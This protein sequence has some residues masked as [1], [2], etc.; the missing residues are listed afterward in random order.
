[1]IQRFE[2]FVTGITVCY[3]YIQRIKS[4]EMVE[5]GLRG[6]HVMCLFYLNRHPEGLTAAQLCSLCAEDKAAISRTLAELVEKGL[7]APPDPEGRKKYR[8]L[9]QLT[10]EGR[11]IADQVDQLCAQWITAGSAGLSNEQRE[12]F[13]AALELI[14]ANLQEN[15]PAGI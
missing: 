9:Q 13:Y 12:S 11:K 1:M 15:F 8:A 6:N 4:A 7:V 3:K 2:A 14:T 10:A 5:F